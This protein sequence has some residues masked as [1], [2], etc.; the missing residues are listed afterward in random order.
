MHTGPVVACH[1]FWHECRGFSVSMCNVVDHVFIFL[2]VVRLICQSAKD[3]TQFVL[4][5]RN[6]VVMFV[7]FDAHAFHCGQH[8]ATDVLRRINWV[9]REIAAF[10]R[11]TVGQV[12]CF[13]FRICVPSRI[14]RIDL[15]RHFGWCDG[16][17]YVV[18]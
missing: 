8:C 6:F 7:N 14:F 18:E 15:E 12:A 17:A 13:E 9:Y 5:G 2:Q 16:I 3:H 10:V 11:C 4:R 1:W